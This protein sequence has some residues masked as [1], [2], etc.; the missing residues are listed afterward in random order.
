MKSNKGFSLVELI[1]VIAIMAII[2]AVAV[3]A[4]SAYIEKANDGVS[5]SLFDEAVYAAKMAVV[6]PDYNDL[7]ITIEAKDG[8]L[9]IS[10][11]NDEAAAQVAG[12]V[13]ATKADGATV[14]S[15]DLQSDT[16]TEKAEVT[17]DGT[18]YTPE[19]S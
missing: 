14:Y 16:Y 12:V 9:T 13:G 7:T 3:P 18:T 11:T 15:A 19:R 10:C 5:Q 2:A 6:E 8:K 4:Y 17:L 1:V